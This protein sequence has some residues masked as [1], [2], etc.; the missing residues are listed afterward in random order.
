M[1][2]ENKIDDNYVDDTEAVVSA[3]EDLAEGFNKFWEKIKKSSKAI[4][5]D[6]Q[7]TVTGD[8][9]LLGTSAAGAPLGGFT[10]VS[11]AASLMGGTIKLGG[12]IGSLSL[13]FV[14]GKLSF[15][16]N[17]QTSIKAAA[18]MVAG[19]AQKNAMVQKITDNF[20][21]A[22]T[23]RGSSAAEQISAGNAAIKAG[24][25]FNDVKNMTVTIDGVL[26]MA[27]NV[28]L[29]KKAPKPEGTHAQKSN[30]AMAASIAGAADS[31]KTQVEATASK[32]S[33]TALGKLYKETELGLAKVSGPLKEYVP[34]VADTYPHETTIP[35]RTAA[36]VE[37][38]SNLY[39]V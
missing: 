15:G 16:L 6:I 30:I 18:G 3:I 28:K 22:L 31:F 10:T 25:S 12:P 38:A 5:D 39:K 17:L 34:G 20:G 11:A 1:T 21:A 33:T 36:L 2:A 4:V 19:S 23:A 9:S 27:Q 7:N 13:S 29:T 26:N 24:T 8:E 32:F 37:K 14:G 35:D